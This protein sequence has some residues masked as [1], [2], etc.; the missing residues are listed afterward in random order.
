[1]KRIFVFLVA[2]AM[3]AASL[4]VLAQEMLPPDPNRLGD[5][6]SQYMGEKILVD[7]FIVRPFGLA[8]MAIGAAGSIV[9]MPW[10]ATSC[11][12]DRVCRELIQK[13]ADFTFTRPVGDLDF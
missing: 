4:P 12:G 7:V 6:G 13:P 1:M 8:A 9:A 2:V 10:A 3:L 5:F 11:S